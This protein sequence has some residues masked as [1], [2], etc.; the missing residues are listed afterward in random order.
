MQPRATQRSGL[1]IMIAFV[2]MAVSVS[3]HAA[4]Q[5]RIASEALPAETP[6]DTAAVQELSD[7]KGQAT[8]D[9]VY[10]T[11]TG[12]QLLA[13]QLQA[14]AK[15]ETETPAMYPGKTWQQY[16]TP[17]EAG[18]SSQKLQAARDYF[19]G[20]DSAAVMIVYNGAVLAA[21]GDVDRRYMCHSIRKSFLSAL[22]G[23]YHD[24]GVIDLNKTLA[25]LQIDDKTPLTEQEKLARISDLLKARSG[26][27]LPAA[28]QSSQQRRGLPPRELYAPG[29]HWYYSNWD[30]NTLATIFNQETG[31]D[32]FQAFAKRIARPL[33]MEDFRLLDTYYHYERHYSIHPA[34]P[35]RMSAKDMARFGL[36]YLRRGNWQGTRILSEAWIR[37]SIHPYSSNDRS[38]YGYMWWIE[39]QGALKTQGIYS[40]LGFGGHAIDILPADRKRGRL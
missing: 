36:L 10:A 39:T 16:A 20:L 22:Y 4:S 33:Q 9:R 7:G 21:W 5:A 12:Q 17:E 25:Q 15:G 27:S 1:G 13:Q 29:T 32:L 2:A 19:E 18:W 3:V 38:G 28:Y 40:A 14:R 6:A 37:D 35:F 30:F 34:Y 8:W 26:V 24:A 11:A 31:S 23:I